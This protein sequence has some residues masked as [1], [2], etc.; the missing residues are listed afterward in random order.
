MFSF[1]IQLYAFLTTC[2]GCCCRRVRWA[3][4]GPQLCEEEVGA[5]TDTNLAGLL[6][7]LHHRLKTKVFLKHFSSIK[8]VFH[9]LFFILI[10]DPLGAALSQVLL[11]QITVSLLFLSTGCP[12]ESEGLHPGDR[13]VELQIRRFHSGTGCHQQ[14]RLRFSADS[15]CLY[16]IIGPH[17]LAIAVPS[18][19]CAPPPPTHTHLSSFFLSFRLTLIHSYASNNG[20]CFL[21]TI[22]VISPNPFL[23]LPLFPSVLR[24]IRDIFLGLFQWGT[25]KSYR[26]TERE[27]RRRVA[28]GRGSDLNPG[29]RHMGAC[30]SRWAKPA[31]K[32]QRCGSTMC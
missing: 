18:S 2:R 21:L 19:L 1:L 9:F 23:Q 28:K 30:S 4:R 5:W 13:H 22:K 24:R 29:I 26:E 16:P 3:G 7:S 31:L 32:N 15:S 10:S 11:P 25:V 20:N 17:Y 27:R 12:V 6:K 14:V 8:F